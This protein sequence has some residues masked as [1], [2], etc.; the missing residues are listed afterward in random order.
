MFEIH[1]LSSH[2]TTGQ[3]KVP[4]SDAF[5]RC[6]CEYFLLF[7]SLNTLSICKQGNINKNKSDRNKQT[8]SQVP[9]YKDVAHTLYI[10]PRN[11]PN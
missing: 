9:L 4:N 10:F 6:L 3:D 1:A 11:L 8:A 5:L 7:F 2:T